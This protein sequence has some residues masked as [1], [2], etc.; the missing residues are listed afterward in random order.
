MVDSA[1]LRQLKCGM[2]FILRKKLE[3]KKR[4]KKMLPN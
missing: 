1:I 4:V 2:K 3:E